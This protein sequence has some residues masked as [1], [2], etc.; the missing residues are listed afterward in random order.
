MYV[1]IKNCQQTGTESLGFTGR[2][3][4]KKFYD[5]AKKS[6]VKI[7]MFLL[8]FIWPEIKKIS[9]LGGKQRQQ[10]WRIQDSRVWQLNNKSKLFYAKKLSWIK[11]KIFKGDI[12]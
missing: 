8:C 7:K 2:K 5:E 6:Q 10:I 3:Y 11:M 4:L 1:T 9:F 12:S